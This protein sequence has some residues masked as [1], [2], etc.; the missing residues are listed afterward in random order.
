[1]SAVAA[2]TRRLHAAV[3]PLHDPPA[4]PGWNHAELADLI[5]SA[6]RRPAAVLVPV[7]ARGDGLSVLF[8]QRTETLAQHAGQI[9]FPGGGIEAADTDAVAAA[10]RETREEVG[11]APDLLR[12]FGFLDCFE[13]ISGYCVTPVVAELDATYR[14]Q[15]DPSEVA[16]VFEAPLALFLDPNNL[17]RRHIIYRNR[18]REVFEFIHGT[19]II[20]GATAAMLLNLVQRMEGPACH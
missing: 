10:L 9:S 15:P 1:M 11:I 14:A 5:G 2:L 13:T 19:R 18:P 6:P 4:G 12:P 3:R 20:W 7:V 16:E 17:R 8:T